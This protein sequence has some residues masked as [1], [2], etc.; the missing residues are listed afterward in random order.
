[1]KQKTK[2]RLAQIVIFL[3][4]VVA[5]FVAGFAAT[6]LLTILFPSL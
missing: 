5:P 3:T 4:F 2:D 6:K 1:M